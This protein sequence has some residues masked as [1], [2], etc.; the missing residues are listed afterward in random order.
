MGKRSMSKIE[1]FVMAS[2]AAE[3]RRRGAL[4]S[5]PLAMPTQ[6]LER[7]RRLSRLQLLAMAIWGRPTR[8]VR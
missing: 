8:A 2:T 4:P 6:R 5:A 1:T 3:V 7:R